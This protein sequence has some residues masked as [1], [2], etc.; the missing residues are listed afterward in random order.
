MT[1]LHFIDPVDVL[2]FRG[3]KLFGDP[4]SYGDSLLPPWPSVAAGALRSLLYA[5]T[6]GTVYEHPEDFRVTSFHLARTAKEGFEAV[7]ALPADLLIT[8]TRAAPKIERSTVIAPHARLATS[9][10][11]PLLPVFGS[12]TRSKPLE[13]YWLTE[14]G[15]C[16]YLEGN[17]PATSD[18]IA[19]SDLWAVETRIGVGLDEKTRRA[20]DGKLFS[21]QAVAF[22]KGVGFIAATNG[23][24]SVPENAAVRIGGDGRAA[25]LRPRIQSLPRADHAAI[26]SSRRARVVLVTPGI[27]ADGW[28][29]PGMTDDGAWRL[30]SVKARIVAAAVPRAEV[31]S[32]WDIK[33]RQPKP[34]QRVAPTGSVYWLDDLEAS[35]ESLD[36]LADDGLWVE[37]CEDVSRKVE[38][39]NRFEFASWK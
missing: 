37:P 2:F 7:F 26:V 10:T 27:F 38:G 13:G 39:F 34:A 8:G 16:K 24:V 22:K 9:A 31:V 30:G 35:K 1:Q 25:T 5:T 11:S 4:G 36:K 28:R 12:T 14:S 20:D 18:L 23:R 15:W 17:V 3:N 33:R 29:L 21:T 32:G 19:T 6:G